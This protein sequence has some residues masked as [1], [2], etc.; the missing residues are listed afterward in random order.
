MTTHNIF[1]TDPVGKTDLEMYGGRHE[2]ICR[3]TTREAAEA[4]RGELS[5]HRPD[6]V[7]QIESC[8]VGAFNGIGC[9]ETNYA[10]DE[11]DRRR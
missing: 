1:C 2:D 6:L 5:C 9:H 8:G 3:A 4:I 10:T 11:E 7:Y